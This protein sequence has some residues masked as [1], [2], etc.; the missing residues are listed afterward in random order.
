MLKPVKVP[1]RGSVESISLGVSHAIAV[2]RPHKA[3]GIR[4]FLDPD[5]KDADVS[6]YSWGRGTYGQLGNASLRGSAKPMSLASN[7][8][9]KKAS[10]GL[11]FSVGIDEQG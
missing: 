2:M 4:Q 1:I 7:L 10:C 3:S 5:A 8:R 9:L 6:A 11:N